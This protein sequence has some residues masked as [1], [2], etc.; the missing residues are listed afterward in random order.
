MFSALSLEFS[1]QKED[2]S[3]DNVFLLDEPDIVLL[4]EK[5]KLSK[6][7]VLYQTNEGI[8]MVNKLLKTNYHVRAVSYYGLGVKSFS[9]YRILT[10]ELIQRYHSGE[11]FLLPGSA[12]FKNFYNIVIQVPEDTFVD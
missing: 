4:K 5:V 8:S 11:K 1:D 9:I 10:I 6:S 2:L 3:L 12:S 7:M